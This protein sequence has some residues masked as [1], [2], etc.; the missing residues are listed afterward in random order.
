MFSSTE[1]ETLNWFGIES[2][3]NNNNNSNISKVANVNSKNSIISRGRDEHELMGHVALFVGHQT[4]ATINNNNAISYSAKLEQQHTLK[5][6]IEGS[7]RWD[8]KNNN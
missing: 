5:M 1:S 8:S 6:Q 7:S 3:N 4:A 2:Y